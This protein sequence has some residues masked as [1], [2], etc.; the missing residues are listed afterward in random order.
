MAQFVTTYDGL[1]S[2][3]ENFVEDDSAEFTAEVQHVINRAEERIF[4]DLD[5]S[6]FNTLAS[7]TT[8]NGVSTLAKS[9][10]ESPVHNILFV[11]SRQHAERRT[12]PF[13]QAL[14]TSGRPLYFAE[15]E[16]TIYW[17]HVTDA[18]YA[19]IITYNRRWTPLSASQQSNW[20]TQNVSD[21][22]LWASLVEAEH[23]LIAPERI[24]EFEATYRAL[25]GPVRAFWRGAAQTGYEPVNP[26]PTP[27]RTR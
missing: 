7:T 24:Q 12:L 22:L 9:F 26:T 16:S 13:V 14:G 11:A 3:L 4:R 20:C 21:L 8:G 10:S 6:L 27:E 2:S 23:F 15:L 25:L 19:I 5:M 18:D 1:V 17:S